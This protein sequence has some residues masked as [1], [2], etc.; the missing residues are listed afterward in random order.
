ME[1]IMKKLLFSIIGVLAMSHG[2]F[3]ATLEELILVNQTMYHIENTMRDA[4]DNSMAYKLAVS[5]S[6]DQPTID[7]VIRIIKLNAASYKRLM[8]RVSDVQADPVKNQK[9]LNGLQAQSVDPQ[10]VI[11]SVQKINTVAD[12]TINAL[13]Q[14]K[15]DIDSLS[16][17]VI[18]LI[19]ARTI[20][21]DAVET[22]P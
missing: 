11:L 18:L 10:E 13:L 3:C 7:N 6:P 9:L 17:S 19:P 22:K 14:N 20:L 8:K 4:R 21:Q 5:T 15:S 2:G 12:L 16:D 1:N